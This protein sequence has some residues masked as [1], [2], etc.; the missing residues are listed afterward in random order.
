MSDQYIGNV[1]E[2]NGETFVTFPIELLNQMG[3]DEH[4]LIEWLIEDQRV[5]IKE[6]TNGEES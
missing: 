5:I 3:W 1:V 4:T 6:V 2:E